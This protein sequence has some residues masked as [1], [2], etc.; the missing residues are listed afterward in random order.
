M[1]EHKCCM[2]M[3]SSQVDIVICMTTGFLWIKVCHHQS[4]LKAY[5][6]G[7]TATVTQSLKAIPYDYQD[8]RYTQML[9]GCWLSTAS[10]DRERNERVIGKRMLHLQY[11]SMQP[12]IVETL[13]KGNMEFSSIF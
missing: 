12:W 8:I 9:L 3:V 4:H 7:M 11:M 2:V 6:T 5:R 13:G 1:H 10:T